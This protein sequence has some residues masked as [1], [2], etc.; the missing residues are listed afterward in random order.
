MTS[1]DCFYILLAVC[2]A[3][4]NRKQKNAKI[5]WEKVSKSNMKI[6]R[7]FFEISL[8]MCELVIYDISFTFYVRIFIF[9]VFTF[10]IFLL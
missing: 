5:L 6:R 2:V 8:N 9:G 7:M 4:K 10:L 1:T 3:K